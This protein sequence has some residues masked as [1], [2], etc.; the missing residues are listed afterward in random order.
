MA[1][2]IVSFINILTFV[3]CQIL[4]CPRVCLFELLLLIMMNNGWHRRWWLLPLRNSSGP[5]WRWSVS[6][7]NITSKCMQLQISHKI[8]GGRY[9]KF[10]KFS[11]DVP[12]KKSAY[13]D[14]TEQYALDSQGKRRFHGAFTGGFTAGHGNS[15]AVPEGWTPQTFKSSRSDRMKLTVCITC[16]YR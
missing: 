4:Y 9:W 13:Q 12:K 2:N 8:K 11:D 10:K 15:V 1:A 16:K 14:I 3:I 5:L 7:Q 6:V